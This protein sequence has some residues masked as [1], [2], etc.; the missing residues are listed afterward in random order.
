MPLIN[1]EAFVGV[2]GLCFPPVLSKVPKVRFFSFFIFLSCFC[3]CLEKKSSLRG[4][5][6]LMRVSNE[7]FYR[8]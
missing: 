7:D 5:F 3:L 1:S 2:R 4:P 6:S 8:I